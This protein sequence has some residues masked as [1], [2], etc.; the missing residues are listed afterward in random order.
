MITMMLPR[1]PSA[2]MLRAT[3]LVQRKVPVRFT[4][5]WRLQRSSGISSTLVSPRMPALLTRMSTPPKF[6][7][8][9]ATVASTCASSVTSQARPRARPPRLTIH[10]AHWRALSSATSTQATAAPSSARPWAMPP[11]MLG[12]V[13]VTMAT[14]PASRLIRVG[15]PPRRGAQ[16]LVIARPLGEVAAEVDQAHVQGPQLLGALEV[17]PLALEDHEVLLLVGGDDDARLAVGVVPEGLP[18]RVEGMAR[19]FHEGE[20]PH[21]RVVLVH[22]DHPAQ[23]DARPDH[24]A[25]LARQL[26]VVLHAPVAREGRLATAILRAARELAPPHAARPVGAQPGMIALTEMRRRPR[27]VDRSLVLAGD[28]DAARVGDF[29]PEEGQAIVEEPPH[30]EAAVEVELVEV[31]ALGHGLRPVRF[32]HLD[33][34]EAAPRQLG[35]GELRGKVLVEGHGLRLAHPHEHDAHPLLG[36]IGARAQFADER[37]LGPLDEPGDAAAG[38]VEDV[39]VIRAGH[40]AL[41]F[42]ESQREACA[43]M[44]APVAESGHRTRL[45]AEEHELV[46]EHGQVDGL[47]AHPL[48]HHGG[49]PVLAETQ[50]RAVVEGADLGSAV[51]LLHRALGESAVAVTAALGIHDGYLPVRRCAG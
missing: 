32:P 17:E 46:A 38:A 12:L 28:L 10:S 31:D 19:S 41:E 20:G 7:R 11:P 36:G 48:R 30:V 5:T 14:L 18:S 50:L 27:R 42:A 9:R 15:P 4:A 8:T 1:R 43:T 26:H 3:C 35:I 2:T 39:A 51:R 44:R 6:A 13:P 49:I 45:V 37:R 24:H 47:A 40:R 16:S 33:A 23:V 25:D 34:E 22:R 21:A 29:G